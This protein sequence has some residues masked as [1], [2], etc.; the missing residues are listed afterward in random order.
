[1]NARILKR[2]L[3]AP[4]FIIGALTQPANALVIGHFDNTRELY[5]MSTGY[6]SGATQWL[7][8]N[9]HTLVSTSEANASFLSTVD[10]FY[11]GLIGSVDTTE[12]S[13][14]QSFVDV[15]G[16]FL[17][18]QQDHDGGSWHGPSS[19]I[20]ANWGIGNSAGTYSND[21]GHTTVGSSTWV[22]EPHLVNGFTGSA[23]STINE[24]PAGFDVLAEDDEGRAIM[25]VFDAG[26]GRSSD[27]FIA[28][29]IDFWSD[30]V[31]W[32]DTRNQNLWEN[33][34][35]AASTQIDDPVSVPEPSTFALLGFGLMFLGL[36]R[37][38]ASA[39]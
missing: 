36:R 8:D 6:L 23:H 5:G 33:I 15:S 20:L 7:A 18:I 4:V 1:M 38:K 17:F 32:G 31:G 28:T 24:I 21:A 30:G 39:A 9:G 26:A 29:D 14:F 34:W 35:T 19:A 2:H 11:T 10:A 22:T 13:A 16:G 3:L 37:R 25:G 27:V 12:I